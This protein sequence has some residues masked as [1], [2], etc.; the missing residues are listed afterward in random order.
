MT[1]PND[2]IP[3]TFGHLMITLALRSL[4]SW[5]DERGVVH[6]KLTVEERGA[7]C[8]LWAQEYPAFADD[9]RAQARQY[10]ALMYQGR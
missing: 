3:A 7:Q 10:G 8:Y 5:R 2:P 1:M 4:D 6:P 9:L